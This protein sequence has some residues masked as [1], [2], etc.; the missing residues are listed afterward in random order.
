MVLSLL[1]DNSRFVP[2]E[3]AIEACSGKSPEEESILKYA[4]AGYIMQVV[5]SSD[6]PRSIWQRDER[7]QRRTFSC[8]SRSCTAS[9]PTRSGRFRIVNPASPPS[10]LQRPVPD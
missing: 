2:L 3:P 8:V 7:T 4:S 6:V 10:L 9:S 1:Q 5:I